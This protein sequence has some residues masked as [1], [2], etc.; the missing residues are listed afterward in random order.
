M[1]GGGRAPMESIDLAGAKVTSWDAHGRAWLLG[2]CS[3]DCALRSGEAEHRRGLGRPP[4]GRFTE[5]AVLPTE[6]TAWPHREI[7]ALLSTY[8][9]H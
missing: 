8:R 1:A 9:S 4:P 2:D 3:A 5:D 7:T 6:L